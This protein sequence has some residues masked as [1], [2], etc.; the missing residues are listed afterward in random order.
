MP[1]GAISTRALSPDAENNAPSPLGGE[2][3]GEG[4]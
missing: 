1:L 4:K 2:G 3:R